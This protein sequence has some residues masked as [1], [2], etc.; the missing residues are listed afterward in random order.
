MK[1]LL[2]YIQKYYVVYAN[3]MKFLVQ[4]YRDARPAPSDFNSK[5][6]MW[7]WDRALSWQMQCSCL[8]HS[9]WSSAASLGLLRA[10]S[11]P[12]GEPGPQHP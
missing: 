7:E 3:L 2:L 11:P 10:S 9:R 12:I 5:E 6:Y 1:T 4:E 8:M